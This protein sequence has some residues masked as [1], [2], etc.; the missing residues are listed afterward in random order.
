VASEPTDAFTAT[1]Q[2]IAVESGGQLPL[3]S[4]TR[5]VPLFDDGVHDDGAMERDGIYGNPLDDV[6]KFEGTYMLHAVATYGDGC[7]GR[8]EATWSV[9]VELGIDPGK[10]SVEVVETGTRPDGGRTGT[11]R[12]TPRDAYGSPLGPGRGDRFDVTPQPGKNSDDN[13]VYVD[14]LR[15]PVTAPSS[16]TACDDPC[17]GLPYF[18]SDRSR[19]RLGVHQL[20][21]S[22]AF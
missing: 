8:R 18:V 19:Y 1:L 7:R 13:L 5:T 16:I 6:L 11:V 22:L 9:H 17:E 4:S 15:L 14:R 2:A 21:V 3:G 12:L 10:T 20:V